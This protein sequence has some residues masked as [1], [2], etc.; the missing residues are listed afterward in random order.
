MGR[1]AFAFSGVYTA[2][3]FALEGLTQSYYYQLAGSGIDVC[4][5]EPGVFYTPIWDKIA[6]F[7]PAYHERA[8]VYKN[9]TLDGKSIDEYKKEMDG[10]IQ[11]VQNAKSPKATEVIPYILNLF[12]ETSERPLRTVADLLVEEGQTNYCDE[13]NKA[14]D[15]VMTASLNH[16]GLS[17]LHPKSLQH[18]NNKSR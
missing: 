6:S 8:E 5:V 14:I 2:S 11:S 4:I 15:K 18:K 16:H 13:M 1:M 12:P 10:F 17:S 9:I 3:K 7:Q